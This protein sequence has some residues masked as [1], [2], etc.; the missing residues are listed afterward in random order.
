LDVASYIDNTTRAF[1]RPDHLGTFW[2]QLRQRK[3]H[4]TNGSGS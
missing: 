3:E 1:L 2:A 4:T